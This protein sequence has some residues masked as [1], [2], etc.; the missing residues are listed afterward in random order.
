MT[1][2]QKKMMK[3]IRYRQRLLN[4]KYCPAI[5]FNLIIILAIMIIALVL[6]ASGNNK[7]EGDY[8]MAYES[9]DHVAVTSPANTPST[10]KKEPTSFCRNF[11]EEE[12]LML[13]KIAMAEAEGESLETKMLVIFTVLNRVEHAQFPDTIKEVIFQEYNGTYQFSPVIPGGRYWTTEPNE[14]CWEAVNIINCNE[15]DFSDGALYFE[16]CVD[17]DNWHSRNLEFLFEQDGMRFYK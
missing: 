3:I 7:S 11:T 9:Q 6:G 10:T 12:K 5:L 2:K 1:R 4:Q 8:Q 17:A 14:E 15:H 13:A 16:S